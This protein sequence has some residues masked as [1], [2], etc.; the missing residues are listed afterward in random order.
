MRP[1]RNLLDGA[2]DKKVSIPKIAKIPKVRHIFGMIPSRG[3][4]S[5]QENEGESEKF[6]DKNSVK[7]I[8]AFHII[9]VPSKSRPKSDRWGKMTREKG[10]GFWGWRKKKKRL[11][12]LIVQQQ[13]CTKINQ[14]MLGVF[15]REMQE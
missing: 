2:V 10:K 9:Y 11:S 6:R 7:N 4:H 13:L 5:S 14:F 3:K 1:L 8:C 12:I 15:I